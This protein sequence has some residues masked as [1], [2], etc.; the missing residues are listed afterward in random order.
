M[1]KKLRATIKDTYFYHDCVN[2]DE[3]R[4]NEFI[5]TLTS[6]LKKI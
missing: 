2:Y 6:E 3:Q 1:L 4:L 5:K